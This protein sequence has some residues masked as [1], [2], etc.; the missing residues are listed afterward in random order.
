MLLIVFLS[1]KNKIKQRKALKWTDVWV[2]WGR[3][4]E[5]SP[6]VL[7]YVTRSAWCWRSFP[8]KTKSNH[9]GPKQTHPNPP[10]SRYWHLE[11]VLQVVAT[12]LASECLLYSHKQFFWRYYL[13]TKILQNVCFLLRIV[14]SPQT[15][16]T[17]RSTFGH[18]Q[19]TD[20]WRSWIFC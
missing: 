17:W 3:T 13:L 18:I 11:A 19:V 16:G 8:Q 9:I 5:N 12:C 7:T 1:G 15:T 2:H 6:F 10:N 4:R 14:V 20:S